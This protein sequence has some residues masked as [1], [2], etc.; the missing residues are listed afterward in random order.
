MD[1]SNSLS[2]RIMEGPTCPECEGKKVKLI[3]RG[4][5]MDIGYCSDC[6]KEVEI[7]NQA[8]RRISIRDR[9]IRSKK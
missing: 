4:V 9:R 2:S 7:S 5:K 6:G 1:K 3:G 8:V